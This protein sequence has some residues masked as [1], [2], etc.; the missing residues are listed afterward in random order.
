MK[1]KLIWGFALVL[2]APCAWGDF[3]QVVTSFPSPADYPI[4]LA[5]GANDAHMW[6]FCNSPPYNIY[7]I[8]AETGSVYE[9][10]ASPWGTGTRGLT[11][12]AGGYLY[13]ADYHAGQIYVV[14]YRNL[15][16][17]ISSFPAG[18]P[19]VMGLALKATGDGGVGGDALWAAM[20]PPLADNRKGVGGRSYRARPRSDWPWAVYLHKRTTGSIISSFWPK[21]G[22]NDVAWDWRN[23]ILWGGGA[24]LAGYKPTGSYVGSFWFYRGFSKRYLVGMCY[25]NQ[26]LWA[27]ATWPVAEILKIHCPLGIA[28]EPASLGKVKA[29]YR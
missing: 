9:S 22:V 3:R 1:T 13:V 27:S 14:H 16:S 23:D 18:Y 11:Y 2:V 25:F 5:R 10:V 29:I 8:N 20:V 28:V 21:L 19:Y 12:A 24:A 6:V 7:R 17:V 15:R 4:A 26:Y